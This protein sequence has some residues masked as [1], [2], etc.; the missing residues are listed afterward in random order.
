MIQNTQGGSIVESILLN[1]Q[2]FNECLQKDEHLSLILAT[3][4]KAMLGDYC[5]IQFL[6]SEELSGE[7]EEVRLIEVLTGYDYDQGFPRQVNLQAIEHSLTVHSLE[8]TPRSQGQI[9][10]TPNIFANNQFN[11]QVDAPLLPR[12]FLQSKAF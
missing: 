6:S 12:S 10:L 11:E 1:S 7:E 2:R 5:D 4:V 8:R 3:Q 9:K